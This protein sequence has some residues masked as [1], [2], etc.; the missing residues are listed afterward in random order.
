MYQNVGDPTFSELSPST[1]ILELVNPCQVFPCSSRGE[2]VS[3]NVGS[4]ALNYSRLFAL[5][6]KQEKKWRLHCLQRNPIIPSPQ[7][8]SST[9]ILELANPCQMSGGSLM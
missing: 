2:G 4:S 5:E 3:E 6:I 1:A 9:A 7:H 8:F